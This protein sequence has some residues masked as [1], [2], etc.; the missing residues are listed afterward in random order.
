MITDNVLVRDTLKELLKHSDKDDCYKCKKILR[1]FADEY[2][3]DYERFCKII[4][5]ES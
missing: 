3:M 1:E 2:H 5:S 4:K